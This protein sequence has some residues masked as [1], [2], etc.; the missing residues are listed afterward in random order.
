MTVVDLETFR[1]DRCTPTE[2]EKLSA[3][4]MAASADV[5][6]QEANFLALVGEFD[7]VNAVAYWDG[8]RSTAHWL[9]WACSI[10]PGTAREHVRVAR[11]LRRLPDTAAA[12]AKGELT[13]S[14]VRE[15]TRLVEE[16]TT[17]DSRNEQSAED[18]HPDD[19]AQPSQA[20]SD[21]AQSDQ[22]QVGQGQTADPDNANPDGAESD[23]VETVSDQTVAAPDASP[24]LSVPFVSEQNLSESSVIEF[25]RACT[26][27]QLARSVTGFRAAEGTSRRRRSRQRVAWVTDD[28]GNVR[29]TAV[30]PPEEGAAVIAAIQAAAEANSTPDPQPGDECPDDRYADQ[31]PDDVRREAYE[32]TRVQAL[33]EIAQHYLSSRPEDRSGEDRTMVVLEINAS[34]LRPSPHATRV[35]EGTF[36]ATEDVPSGTFP[37]SATPGQ[38]GSPPLPD[39][40]KCRVRGGSSIDPAAGRRALCDSSILGVIIDDLGEPLAVGRTQRLVTRAQR[41]ALMTRD[42]KCQY[43]GCPQRRHLKAHHQLSW[44]DGGPTDLDNLILLCQFHHTRVHE[45]EITITRCDHP[46]CAVRWWF[47][48]PDG[49]SI[50]PAVAVQGQP[51]PW[52]RLIDNH[53][54]P[55]TGPAR[56]SAIRRNDE[57]VAAYNAREATLRDQAA[58]LQARYGHIGH[59][60]HPDARR[61]FPVGGGA[62]FILAEC[63]QA[64]FR[65]TTPRTQRAA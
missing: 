48:R 4:V 35:P 11:A 39:L 2:A 54:R 8:L 22:D 42:G 5:A 41:R 38:T 44:L 45:D 13:Y 10:A 15:V 16:I 33:C 59:T 24:E 64:L 43:P 7:A 49:T 1:S 23:R 58:E 30:L 6:R 25:A 57:R 50:A 60:D 12:F 19:H 53:G 28:E 3:R 26:A 34:A 17:A 65:M 40:Q 61:V 9:S 32:R 62:G 55:L 47:L 51:H 52:R 36:P 31:L 21:H 27:S 29:I 14:K 18:Q 37:T 63:V 56:E 20:Q 46:S